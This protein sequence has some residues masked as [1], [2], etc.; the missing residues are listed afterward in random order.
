MTTWSR[1]PSVQ[2]ASGAG[3]HPLDDFLDLTRGHHDVGQLVLA[4]AHHEHPPG[5]VDPDLFHR[6]VVE[7]RG[8][9]AKSGHPVAHELDLF[10][11]ER[12]QAAVEEPLSIVGD[13]LVEQPVQLRGIVKRHVA[14]E[15]QLANFALDDLRRR[16]RR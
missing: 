6:R 15:H 16:R 8:E 3:Q 10:V 5:L 1:L 11:G 2:P 12:G 13:D 9:R 7:Q 14:T 4:V